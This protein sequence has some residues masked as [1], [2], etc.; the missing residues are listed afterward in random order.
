MKWPSASGAAA[1]IS[2]ALGVSIRVRGTT[3]PATENALSPREREVLGR[4]RPGPR[5]NDWLLGRAALKALLDG[6][7]TSEV[8]FPHRRL[9]LTHAAGRAFATGG[10]GEQTLGLG[11]DF[12]GWRPT[13]PRTARF[14][15]HDHERPD[16]RSPDDELLRRWTIKEALFK[17]TPAN[18]RMALL[19]YYLD[20]PANPVG[21]ATSS[22]GQVLRYAS[23]F[24]PHGPLT[25]AITTAAPGP[26]ANRTARSGDRHGAA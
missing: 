1:E 24:L 3:H 25:V 17:A 14:F 4:L 18:S 16:E 19:D 13:D 9:S 5:R 20:D 8:R 15:L 12:E 23:G 26:K 11:I 22:R 2:V 7:D 10:G 21:R 6:A